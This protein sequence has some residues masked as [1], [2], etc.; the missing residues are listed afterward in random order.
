MRIKQSSCSCLTLNRGW[1]LAG[2]IVVGL[3]SAATS[4]M[5]IPLSTYH[6]RVHSS[7]I[8]LDTLQTQNENADEL[9][10]NSRIAETLRQVRSLLPATERIEWD[11]SSVE[12][13][14]RWLVASLEVFEG[15]DLEAERREK[16]TEIT[17]RLGAIDRALTELEGK[18][19]GSI[20]ST[21]KDESKARLANILRRDEFSRKTEEGSALSR[22]WQRFMSWLR[23]MMPKGPSIEPGRANIL[24]NVA[25]IVVVALALGLI[26]F[27]SWKFFPHILRRIPKSKKSG[28]REARVVLGERLEPDQSSA[29]L[30]AEAEALAR[31]GNLRGAIRKGYIAALCELGD[32]KLLGLAQHKTNRDYLRSL[33]SNH[34]LYQEMQILTQSFEGHWYGFIPANLNDWNAFRAHYQRAL[35]T[36]A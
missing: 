16:L 1:I 20:N 18:D 8:A 32:R 7:L 10:Q 29:D 28:K 14:N 13:D 25:Q 24:S 36:Q 17:E 33:R 6:E 12:V 26:G 21:S 5:A 19:A 27:V 34:Q 3:L 35:A 15:L 30:L 31:S 2:C 22:L 23:G 9:S 11:G 4:A